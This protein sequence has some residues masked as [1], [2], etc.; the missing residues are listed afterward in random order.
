MPSPTTGVS[1]MLLTSSHSGLRSVSPV[2]FLIETAP[3]IGVGELRS[4]LSSGAP[5]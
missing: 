2:R 4:V 3:Q 5:R 1:R